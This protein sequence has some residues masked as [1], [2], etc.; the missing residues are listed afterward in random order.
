MVHP[1][2][3]EQISLR[4]DIKATI[5]HLRAYS[6]KLRCAAALQHLEQLT[7]QEGDAG[8]LRRQFQKRGSVESIVDAALKQFRHAQSVELSLSH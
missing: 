7:H 5:G 2:T 8:Y 4:E 3:Y 6:E 1:K